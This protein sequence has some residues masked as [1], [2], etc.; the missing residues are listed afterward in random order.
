MKCKACGALNDAGAS[1]CK[2]C[3]IKLEASECYQCGAPAD[4]DALFCSKCGS[5]L[6]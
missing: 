4:P 6:T 1:F 3:G 2:G 5:K